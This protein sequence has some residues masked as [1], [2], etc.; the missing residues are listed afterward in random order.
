MRGWPLSF[1]GWDRAQLQRSV[2]REAHASPA[3]LPLRY[4]PWPFNQEQHGPWMPSS[5]W[6][7]SW[8]LGLT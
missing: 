6:V 3:K 8:S 7:L 4:G 5:D 1:F 2:P